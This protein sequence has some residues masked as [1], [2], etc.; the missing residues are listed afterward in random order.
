M[1][2]DDWNLSSGEE[3]GFDDW[4]GG[5]QEQA[6]SSPVA[7]HSTNRSDASDTD[8]ENPS[9]GK[10]HMT[11]AFFSEESENDQ[12]GEEEIDWEDGH[13][14]EQMAEAVRGNEKLAADNI[15]EIQL[16]PVTLDWSESFSK[17]KKA[18][19]KRKRVARRSYRFE[20]LPWDLQRFLSNLQKSHLLCLTG[21]AIRSS[22]YCSEEGGVYL[23]HSLIPLAWMSDNHKKKQAPTEDDLANFCHFFF[24]LVRQPSTTGWYSR[25]SKQ[26][27]S[28]GKNN[29][30]SGTVDA[31]TIQYRIERYCA[32]LAAAM[33]GRQQ[34]ARRRNTSNFNCYDK[35]HL[36][37]CMVRYVHSLFL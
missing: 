35:L 34:R 9:R 3:E 16:K 11:V 4:T 7:R 15:N 25:M 8:G 19:N 13:D 26:K 27:K 36:L 23:A 22:E 10:G 24:T 21:H 32:H 1:S 6:E 12:D 33:A 29:G 17:K 5:T 20:H 18:T 14:G 31:A 37:L 2:F 28:L 30:N